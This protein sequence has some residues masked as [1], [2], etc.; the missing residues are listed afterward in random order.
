MYFVCLTLYIVH[1]TPY[2]PFSSTSMPNVFWQTWTDKMAVRIKKAE[3]P[4]AKREERRPP[5]RACYKFA[6]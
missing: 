6:Q 5:R 4:P 1:H 3:R 2:T